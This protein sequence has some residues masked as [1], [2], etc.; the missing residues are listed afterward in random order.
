MAG[1]TFL[2]SIIYI[3]LLKW[4]TKPLLYISMVAILAA[5]LLLGM[6]AWIK[7]DD[8]DPKLESENYNYAKAGAMVAWVFAGIYFFFICCCWNNISLGASIMEA[9]SVFVS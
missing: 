3:F 8:Y 7:K 2:I 5:F 9:A 1:A 4:I 6:W